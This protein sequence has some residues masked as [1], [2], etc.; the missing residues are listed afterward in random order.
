MHACVHMSSGKQVPAVARGI[1]NSGVR[2]S[3]GSGK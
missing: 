3:G 1:G 2:V